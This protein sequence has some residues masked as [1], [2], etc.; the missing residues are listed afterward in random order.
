MQILCNDKGRLT[1]SKY[2][3]GKWALENMNSRYHDVIR[4]AMEDYMGNANNHYDAEEL[5]GFARESMNLI[6]GYL[7]TN[8]MRI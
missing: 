2:D 4:L 8:K 1:L 6:N 7:D 3:G 5:R